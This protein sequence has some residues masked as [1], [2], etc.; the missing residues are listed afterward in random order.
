[1]VRGLFGQTPVMSKDPRRTLPKVDVLLAHPLLVPY[2]AEWGPRPLAAAARRV[3]NVSRNAIGRGKAP[4]TLDALVEHVI[5][6]FEATCA[7]RV[8]AVINAT[9]VVLH[10]NLGRAPLSPAARNAVLA[11]TGYSTVEFDLQTGGRGKRGCAA[12]AMLQ[13]LTGAPG[14]LVVNNAAAA[15]LLSL[16]ALARGREVIVSRGQLIEIGGEFRIPTIMEAAGVTLVEVGTTNR[17]HLRDYAEAITKSTA[18][19]LLIHPSNYRIE[20]F[21]A[22]PPLPALVQLAHQHEI[23]LLHDIGSGLLRGTLGVEPTVEESLKHHADLVVFS[24]DK[25]FGG[26]QAGLIVGVGELVAALARHPIARAVRIDKLTLAALEATLL[27][28]L[29]DRRE[30]LPVWKF[31]ELGPDDLRPRLQKIAA[32]LGAVATLREGTSIAGGGSL[33]GEGLPSLLLDINPH[34]MTTA[35]F[36]VRLRAASPPIIARTEKGRIVIDLRTVPDEQDALLTS[37][38]LRTI[39]EVEI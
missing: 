19:L 37:I 36:M 10:T 22:S 5:E 12:H 11:A 17:T 2:R 24:G 18:M 39:K 7:R 13:E 25:L 23:P 6:Y 34:P 35:M 20:G 38:L 30:E 28:H 15:L 16:G 1:M 8:C 33:P 31:L 14:A 3:L 9:G 26:P 4:P 29:S 27:A 32:Q 21:T